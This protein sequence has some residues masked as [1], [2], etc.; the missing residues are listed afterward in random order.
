[1][2]EA[3]RA[4]R[5]WACAGGVRTP[6]HVHVRRSPSV[7]EGDPDAL[8]GLAELALRTPRAVDRGPAAPRARGDGG[9]AGRGGD[10]RRVGREPS[11]GRRL[12]GAG[13]RVGSRRQ[14]GRAA[15][16]DRLGR[17]AGAV[18]GS[19][20]RRP[21]HP[22]RH[23][24]PR[25]ARAGARG[26]GRGRRDLVLRHRPGEPRLARWARDAGDRLA[27]RQQRRE[28]PHAR[29]HR[30][31]A[32]P[33]R[34]PGR[35]G[36]RRARGRLGAG[37]GD[38]APGHHLGRADRAADRRGAHPDLLPQRG[39]GAAADRDR[40]LRAGELRRDHAARVELHGDRDLRLERGRVPRA[41]ALDR[42]LAAAGA[43]LPA[44][45]GPRAPGARGGRDLARHRR[46]R[47]LGVGP[48]R[49]REP[50]G[51]DR[52]P[53]RDPAQRRDR[54]RA[55][56]RDRAGRRAPAAPGRARLARSEG[57]P[58][59][60]REIRPRQT[61]PS[62]FWRRIGELSMRHP[63]A[64]ALRLRRYADRGREP[65]AAHAQRA[66]RHAHLPAARPR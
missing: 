23:P 11:P 43:A 60:H 42:L 34:G 37:A 57:Q 39:R 9:A 25:P 55:R 20:R 22:V 58:R 7:D 41:R 45:A 29:A 53:G 6:A 5:F 62:P 3:V 10:L 48:R 33:D 46:P 44:G 51:A 30:S 47:R 4:G 13:Q 63:V 38:R 12:R 50:R 66:A 24:D 40:R 2:R 19:R 65:G 8:R 49:D 18:S 28:A 59:R 32:A 15:L 56:H 35:G 64:T 14:G 31:A 61:G 36:D 17:R 21:Q 1:M 26:R 27:R 54:R 16:R 52:L